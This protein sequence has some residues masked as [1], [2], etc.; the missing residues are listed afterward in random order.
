MILSSEIDVAAKGRADWLALLRGVRADLVTGPTLG[1]MVEDLLFILCS[2]H[3]A[4]EQCDA[5]LCDSCQIGEDSGRRNRISVCAACHQ[6][7][8]CDEDRGEWRG[9]GLVWP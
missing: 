6:A 9:D 7:N 8:P 4:C 3:S 1:K 2:S 5:T